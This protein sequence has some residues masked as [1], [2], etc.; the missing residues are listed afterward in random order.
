[1]W[2][3]V[4]IVLFVVGIGKAVNILLA[5]LNQLLETMVLTHVTLIFVAVGLVMFLLP[6]V[7][8]VPVYLA[9]GICLTN[10]AWKK[11]EGGWSFRSAVYFTIFVCFG[12]KLLAVACQ[13]KL[14]GERMGH[15]VA[16][17]TVVSVNS[18]TIKAIKFILQ[19]P[20]LNIQKVLLWQAIIVG[21]SFSC[22][23]PIQVAILCG[24]PDWPTS[25]LTG[26]YMG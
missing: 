15:S 6:P 26:M 10:A 24:G 7:P 23:F 17:R 5:E 19:K 1:M 9:G 12:I 8:G 14:I 18:I 13:Q 21:Y 16:I 20:G 4:V 2:L 11:G 22:L 3:G 25:V